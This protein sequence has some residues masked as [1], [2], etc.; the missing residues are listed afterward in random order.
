MKFPNQFVYG[1]SI[2]VTNALVPIVGYNYGARSKERIRQATRLALGMVLA[3]MAAGTLLFQLAPHLLLGLFHASPTMIEIGTPALRIISGSFCFAGVAI[4][5]SSV[6]QVLHIFVSN[7]KRSLN[8][9]IGH[10]YYRNS[11]HTD[12]FDV[13]C[14]INVVI[15][16]AFCRYESSVS[17]HHLYSVP[18]SLGYI[19]FLSVNL[20]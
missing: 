19:E 4:T 10:T 16:K 6:F 14:K 7:N 15:S 8:C 1:G 2:G 11:S 9:T 12:L 20:R 13:A 18:H 3:I 5:F 17:I